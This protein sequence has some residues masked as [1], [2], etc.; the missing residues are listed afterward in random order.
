MHR[1]WFDKYWVQD[2][3]L[4]PET[5]NSLAQPSFLILGDVYRPYTANTLTARVG[6]MW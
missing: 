2:Y 3:A 6:Y 5:L 4:N 1:Y